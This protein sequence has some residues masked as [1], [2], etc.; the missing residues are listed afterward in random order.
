[1]EEQ[2]ENW[3]APPLPENVPVSDPPQMSEAATLLNIFV[4][5]GATFE[6]LKRKPRFIMAA[7]II[8]ILT[9]AFSFGMSV[10]VGEPGL[11]RFV[12]QQMDKNPQAA[13]L[14]AETKQKSIG[15]QMTIM[16]V[17]RYLVPIFVLIALLIGGLFYFAGGKAFGGRA[18]FMESVSVFVY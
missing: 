14:D 4:D 12:E 7:L 10:K 1:M 17:T 18:G 13:S 11:R 6:D 9:F 16:K 3:E 15:L 2:S 5:P 8:A